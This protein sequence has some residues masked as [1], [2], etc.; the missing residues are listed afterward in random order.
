M[1]VLHCT[2]NQIL[3]KVIR[4][5]NRPKDAVWKVVKANKLLLWIDGIICFKILKDRVWKVFSDIL[6]FPNFQ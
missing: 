4:I 2:T 5:L 6:G 3:L 1:C